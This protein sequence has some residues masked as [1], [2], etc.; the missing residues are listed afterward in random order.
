MTTVWLTRQV[1]DPERELANSDGPNPDFALED[2]VDLPV[3]VARL[4]V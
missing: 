2:L 3:L 1:V 4:S